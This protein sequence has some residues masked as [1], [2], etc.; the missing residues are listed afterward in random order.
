MMV[1]GVGPIY[2]AESATVNHWYEMRFIIA[3]NHDDITLSLGYLYVRDATTGETEFRLLQD[4]AGVNLGLTAGALAIDHW[5]IEALRN[6]GQMGSL[7]FGTAQSIPEPSTVVLTLGTA[8]F[9]GR[10]FFRRSRPSRQ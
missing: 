1:G 9:A 4:I 10:R 5:R 6:G 8:L 7:S 3:L 2:S